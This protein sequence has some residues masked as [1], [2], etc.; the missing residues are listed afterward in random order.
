MSADGSSHARSPEREELITVVVTAHRRQ[1]YL[2]GALRSVVGQ[3]LPR[4]RFEVIL[5]R[6]FEDPEIERY[7]R[8]E[9][10]REIPLDAPIGPVFAAAL[11]EAKGRI[12][13]FLDDD[14]LWVPDRLGH[15]ADTFGRYP[16]VG[17][18]HNQSQVIDSRGR[19]VAYRRNVDISHR[20]ST[21]RTRHFD[22]L[23]R[24]H[25]LQELLDASAEF[26][27]SS[28]AI[29][30]DLVLPHLADLEQIS[31]GA[32]TFLFFVACLSGVEIYSAPD[33]LT[34]YRLSP[35]N[36]SWH[37]TAAGRAEPIVRQL[38][39]VRVLLQLA[40][41]RNDVLAATVANHLRLIEAE[42]EALL[43]IFDSRT[44]RRGM[45]ERLVRVLR[46]RGARNSLWSR[47]LALG[48]TAALVSPGAARWLYF[49]WD[50]ST[51]PR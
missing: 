13:T 19:P 26:N 6:D 24:E 43:A 40:R 29:R 9:G 16:S 10:I 17:Y 22:H 31:G 25:R 3:N 7:C 18:Y 47:V 37:S 36:I 14:D 30:R 46:L 1:E 44:S 27:H 39:T 34:L 45:A 2:P 50:R 12:V 51:R 15:L 41:A 33:R 4:S 5:V 8:Q 23:E 48:S 32:D 20:A 21:N 11:R 35:S 38:K 42:D 28:I 49:L